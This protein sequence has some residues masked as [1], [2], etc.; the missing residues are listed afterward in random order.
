MKRRNFLGIT[1]SALAVSFLDAH[2]LFAFSGCAVK[3]KTSAEQPFIKTL[4]LQT[5]CSFAEMKKFYSETIGLPVANESKNE[6]TIQGGETKITFEYINQKDYRP[7]YHFAFNIPENKIQKAFEWQRKKTQ[8][9]HPNPVGPRDA[10]TDFPHWNAHSIFFLDPAGNLLEYIARHD[11]KNAADGDFT[12][13]DI[14][15]ASEIGFITDDI[16]GDGKN[17][18]DA[19]ALKEYR[20]ASPGFWPI[21]DEHGLLLMIGKGKIWSSNPGQI[22]KT[23]VFK[24][25]VTINKKVGDKWMLPNHPYSITSG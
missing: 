13:R 14:L 20:S 19:L 11:L 18:L 15:Y 6:L 22:N 3:D 4:R 21:G 2:R 12:S 25:E 10:I 23:D 1:T 7:F 8:V 24:T 5:A 9:L 16:E 17:L